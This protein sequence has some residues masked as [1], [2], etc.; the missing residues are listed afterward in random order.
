MK[1]LVDVTV[2]P[3]MARS[4]LHRPSSPCHLSPVTAQGTAHI[5]STIS[6]Q[7]YHLANVIGRPP[8]FFTLNADHTHD[9]SPGHAGFPNET[10]SHKGE[11]RGHLS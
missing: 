6:F 7:T 5:T 8:V 9:L 10:G 4:S 3:A 11:P 1:S 2:S